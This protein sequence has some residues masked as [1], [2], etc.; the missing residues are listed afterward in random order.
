MSSFETDYLIVGSGLTGSTLARLLCDK[1]LKVLVLDRRNHLGGNVYDTLHESG[2][3]VHT[4]GPHYFRTTSEEI[5]KYVN[6]FT[7]FYRYEACVKSFVDGV[8]EN[9]PISK[10]Y[11]LREIGKDWKCA[12]NGKASNFEEAALSLMPQKVYEKFVRGY[13]IK[14]WGIDPRFLSTDLVKRFD[15]RMD[16]NPLLTPHHKYQGIPSGGYT[17]FIENMLKGI[18]L[19]LNCDYLTNKNLFTAHKKVIF[20]GPID[21]YFG[22][23]YGKLKY[24][25]QK[26]QQEYYPDAEYVQPCGQVNNPDLKNGEHIRTLEW[27]H[28]MDM[29]VRA[30]IKGSVITK[31]ITYTPSN[32]E[33][34]EYPFPDKI[35]KDLYELYKC[36]A[37]KLS[38]LL[39]CGRLGEYRYYDMDQTIERAFTLIDSIL[40]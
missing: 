12:F 28:M 2:V 21:E 31:E 36:D 10:S 8:Y 5:W 20:T 1:G 7:Q 19:I 14:Q 18:P 26:R 40:I 15:V 39:I 29:S 32:A 11:I 37:Q 6:R 23:R 9:W 16:D 33:D 34:Y 13:T 4:Y 38:S 24:R 27:K 17:K 25:G 3:R 30:N 22:Y 35:N